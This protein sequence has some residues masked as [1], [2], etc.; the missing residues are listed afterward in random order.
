MEAQSFIKFIFISHDDPHVGELIPPTPQGFLTVS[1]LGEVDIGVSE[2]PPGDHV[3]AYPNGEHRSG[4]AEFL[5]QHSLRDVRVQVTNVER[6]HRITPGRC[7]H[8]PNFQKEKK[9][10]QSRKKL[11]S[12]LNAGQDAL[13][14]DR[15]LS[16]KPKKCTKK[17]SS[18]G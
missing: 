5:I 11:Q 3:S 7:V 10:C 9:I 8:F 1:G 16:E 14:A 12:G 6:S 18:F 4:G 13:G 17:K 2:G 15:S